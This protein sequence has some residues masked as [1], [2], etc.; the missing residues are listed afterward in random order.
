[1]GRVFDSQHSHEFA[2][3][4]RFNGSH[5][6]K[7]FTLIE[8]LVVIAIIG[9]LSSVVLTNLNNTR[10]KARDVKRISDILQLKLALTLYFD[11][12]GGKY[13]GTLA[14]GASGLAPIYIPT[15]PAPPGGVSGVT[16][17]AYVPLDAGGGTCNSYHLGT[18]LEV[19]A[20]SVLTSDSDAAA[21]TPASAVNCNNTGT[22]AS[23]DFNGA[24]VL[25]NA[26]AGSDQCYDVTP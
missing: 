6:S 22:P 21:G 14:S 24:S 15:I 20:N 7:G 2:V 10:Q 18:A 12:N 25:C 3:S 26:T 17:Y 16:A 23:S 13:P 8:L 5:R 1:M 4:H 19:S 11:A 9:I